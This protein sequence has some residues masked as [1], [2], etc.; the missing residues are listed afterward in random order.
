MTRLDQV[1]SRPGPVQTRDHTACPQ[2]SRGSWALLISPSGVLTG[3]ERWGISSKHNLVRKKGFSGP[4]TLGPAE[5]HQDSTTKAEE[6]WS[7]TPTKLNHFLGNNVQYTVIK[8]AQ[9]HSPKSQASFMRYISAEWTLH[10]LVSLFM[11]RLAELP[12][13]LPH[14]GELSPAKLGTSLARSHR[15]AS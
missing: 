2:G 8:K 15:W 6:F 9:F 11:L 3:P 4:E 5:T 1:Q 12:S 10:T 7:L 13:A 14:K